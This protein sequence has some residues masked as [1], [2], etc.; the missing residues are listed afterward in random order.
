MP[1]ILGEGPRNPDVFSGAKNI[2]E[3][4]IKTFQIIQIKIKWLLQNKLYIY[5]ELYYIPV[6]PL[7]ISSIRCLTNHVTLDLCGILYTLKKY[8]VIIPFWFFTLF[9][10]GQL[11]SW[12]LNGQTWDVKWNKSIVSPIS[13]SKKLIIG[14]KLDLYIYI[15]KISKKL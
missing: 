1:K 2:P 4:N 6:A 9:S 5:F 8:D 11:I 15:S 12:I 10:L 7:I 13:S 14:Q 3:W